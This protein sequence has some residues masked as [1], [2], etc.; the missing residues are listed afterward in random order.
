MQIV[1]VDDRC[2]DGSIDAMIRSF[3]GLAQSHEDISFTVQDHRFEIGPQNNDLSTGDECIS[4]SLD[5]VKSPRAG[6]ACAL[7]HGLGYC[8]ADLVARMDADDIVAPQRL[9]SQIGFMHVN[10]S[11]DVVG[12]STV[13]FSARSKGGKQYNQSSI[14]PYHNITQNTESCYVLRSSLS[15]SDPGF[16]AW[17]MLFTCTVSHPSVIFRKKA[18]QELGGYDESI[19]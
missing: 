16:M 8:R 1:V 14:L 9:L 4:I 13:L 18:I 17:A 5:I 19:S 15:I 3:Y 6:V 11:F 2:N 12:T 10:P 7:N